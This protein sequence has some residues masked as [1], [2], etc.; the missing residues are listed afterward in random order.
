MSAGRCDTR[1]PL[2]RGAVS[3][4]TAVCHAPGRTRLPVGVSAHSQLTLG[5]APR[6]GPA[7]LP[8]PPLPCVDTG[9]LTLVKPETL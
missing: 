4:T 7:A 8:G 1:F 5:A 2:G 6:S 3:R 9:E